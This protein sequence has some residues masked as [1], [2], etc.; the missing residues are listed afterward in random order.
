MKKKLNL[1]PLNA[2]TLTNSMDIETR[3]KTQL[4]IFYKKGGK[5]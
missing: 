3:N 5:S 4:Y 2:W 1:K